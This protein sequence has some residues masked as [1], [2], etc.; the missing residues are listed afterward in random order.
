MGRPHKEKF[1]KHK[2]LVF[3]AQEDCYIYK[4]PNTSVWQCFIS[5]PLEGEI[6]KSTFVKGDDTD[7]E[8]GKVLALSIGKVALE[9]LTSLHLLDEGAVLV[10]VEVTGLVHLTVVKNHLDRDLTLVVLHEV[11][12]GHRSLEADEAGGKVEDGRVM[13]LSEHTSGLQAVVEPLPA[14]T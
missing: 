2:I 12:E 9:D 4:R 3:T 5:I 1:V 14:T 7:I 13:L 8:V 6:R 10:D 11:V